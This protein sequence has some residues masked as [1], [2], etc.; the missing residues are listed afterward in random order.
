MHSED[1]GSFRG[2]HGSLFEV[3][4]GLGTKEGNYDATGCGTGGAVTCIG[5]RVPRQTCQ[6][7]SS[8]D[9]VWQEGIKSA[10]LLHPH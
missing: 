2:S 9:R 4:V 7:A 6:N 5:M 3:L 1:T 8:N 10:S